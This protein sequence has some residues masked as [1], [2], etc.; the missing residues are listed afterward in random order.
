MEG[1]VGRLRAPR[2]EVHQQREALCIAVLTRSVA[3]T[4]ASLVMVFTLQLFLAAGLGIDLA[5]V[6]AA[7]AFLESE[8][9][10][11]S[12]IDEDHH[13]STSE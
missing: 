12:T 11:Y 10:L 8:G 2:A 5:R 7:V 9:H 4:V 13:K 6:R 3:A 1:R